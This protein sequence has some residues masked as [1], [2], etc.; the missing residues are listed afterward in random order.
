MSATGDAGVLVVDDE[1]EVTDLYERW[2]DEYDPHV[3]H[4]GDEAIA[5]LD[6]L[7]DRIDVVLLDRKM[8]G[9]NGE[10]VLAAIREREYDCRVAMITA[11]K[12]D[13][14]IVEMEFDDYVTKP[15]DGE[16][17]RE[18]VES[19]HRRTQYAELLTRYYSLAAKHASLREELPASELRE[20]EEF[21]RLELEI[22]HVREELAGTVDFDDHRE[23]QHLLRELD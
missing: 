21:A 23:V 6:R 20:S 13:Y 2:L 5:A 14:D 8:P 11:V 9:R 12:P 1:S 3:V 17:L 7:G 10:D 22:E 19:L 4:D 16:T 18:T 15:V